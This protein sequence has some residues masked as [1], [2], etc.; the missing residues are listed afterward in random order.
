M[1]PKPLPPLESQPKQ[2]ASWLSIAL[3]V[4]FGGVMAAVLTVLT[5]GYFG[6]ILLI[7]LAIFLVVG[8]Q[9][10]LWGWLFERIYRSGDRDPLE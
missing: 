4:F 8:V 2:P 5:L 3:V 6:P 7:G 1:P 9:Y 10:L